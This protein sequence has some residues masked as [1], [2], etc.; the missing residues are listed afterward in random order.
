MAP[1]N[2]KSPTTCFTKMP[3]KMP[4]MDSPGNNEVIHLLHQEAFDEETRM[5]PGNEDVTPCQLYK[6]ANEEAM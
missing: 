5:P 1:R 6:D 3:T 2:E 4:Q